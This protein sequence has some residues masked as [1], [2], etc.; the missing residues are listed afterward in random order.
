MHVHK[1]AHDCTR[2]PP[3]LGLRAG[4]L[5]KHE[6]AYFKAR[7]LCCLQVCSCHPRRRRAFPLCNFGG[8]D[9]VESSKSQNSISG[10]TC[11]SRAM[12]AARWRKLRC[13]Q[14]PCMPA[15][16]LRNALSVQLALLETHLVLCTSRKRAPLPFGSCTGRYYLLSVQQ[17]VTR[18]AEGR[19]KLARRPG[20]PHYAQRVLTHAT[21]PGPQ[22]H[23]VADWALHCKVEKVC[24]YEIGRLSDRSHDG[25]SQ[26]LANSVVIS[27]TN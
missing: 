8:F 10:K 25:V 15:P 16:Q 26:T 1:P 27:D 6:A 12:C 2:T 3:R 4:Q 11:H 14:L 5:H 17:N 19:S 23:A 22:S 18:R 7:G 9:A 24:C 13:H 20:T 21:A